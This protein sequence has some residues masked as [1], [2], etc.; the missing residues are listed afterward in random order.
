[1]N[2]WIGYWM[3]IVPLFD[4]FEKDYSCTLLISAYLM[5]CEIIAYLLSFF[6]LLLMFLSFRYTM[7]RRPTNFDINVVKY[8]YLG[9]SLKSNSSIVDIHKTQRRRVVVV[10]VVVALQID[11]T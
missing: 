7:K 1:M 11:L 3:V 10:I 5:T 9:I 2:W 6:H 4:E 8:V